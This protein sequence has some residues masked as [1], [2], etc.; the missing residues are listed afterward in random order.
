MN[1]PIAI[2]LLSLF[3][4]QAEL[5]ACAKA[6]WSPSAIKYPFYLMELPYSYNFLEPYISSSIVAAHHDHHH[7]TYVTKLNAYLATVSSL[8]TSTL[9][10]LVQGAGSNVSLQKFA[11]GDF[12][13]NMLWWETTSPSCSIGAPT[14]NLAN[15]INTAFGNFTN[16]QT[17][18]NTASSA[19]FGSGW[20]WLCANTTGGLLITTTANQVNPLMTGTCNPVFGSDLWEH[21]YYLQYMYNKDTYFA[22]FWNVIDWVQV[23]YFYD[24]YVS[25]GVPIPF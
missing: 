14:G 24:N 19:L 8:Q 9:L 21:A 18:F 7:Q 16:F 12:N 11:G 2:I 13:H 23:G 5:T 6:T 17:Q 22:N 3:I 4:A 10:S 25:R 15:D 20:A 1:K